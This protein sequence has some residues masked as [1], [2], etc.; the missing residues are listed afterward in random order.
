MSKILCAF[1]LHKWT[2]WKR[3]KFTIMKEDKALA[4]PVDAQ[5]RECERCGKLQRELIRV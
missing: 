5:D 1:G 3:I 2:K 4:N